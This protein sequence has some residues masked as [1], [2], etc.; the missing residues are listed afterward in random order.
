[1]EIHGELVEADPA[2]R[3]LEPARGRWWQG[4][5]RPVGRLAQPDDLRLAGRRAK[6]HQLAERGGGVDGA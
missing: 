6:G 1:M 3:S 4:D 2:E 5:G